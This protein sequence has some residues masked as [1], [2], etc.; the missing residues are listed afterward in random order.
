MTTWQFESQSTTGEWQKA[1]SPVDKTLYDVAQTRYGPV[2]V[3]GSGLIVARSM[4]D[5][6]WGVL[7]DAGPGAENHVLKTAESTDDGGRVWFG[8]KTGA[9]G[10]YDLE[11][12]AKYDLSEPEGRVPTWNTMAVHGERGSEKLLLATTSGQVMLGY[13]DGVD[14]TWG[15]MTKPDGTTSVTATD[16]AP[17]GFGYVV[18]SNGGAF[19]TSI[20]E[21]WRRIGIDGAGTLGGVAAE[22][23]SLLVVTSSGR[24]YRYAEGNQEWTPYKVGGNSLNGVDTQGK[25]ALAVGGSG[26]IYRSYSGSWYEAESPAGNTLQ[27]VAM[28]EVDVA[29]GSGGAIVERLTDPTA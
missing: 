3:G 5:G 1:K 14:V 12:G 26:S 18:N 10:F 19:K 28:G 23:D 20:Y 8:G 21:G 16:A 17:D 27:A 24:A 7:Y 15:Q 2:A 9:L 29:V 11:E 13:V 6:N 22:K 25:E 4:D